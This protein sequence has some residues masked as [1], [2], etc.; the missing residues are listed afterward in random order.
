[1]AL[2][3]AALAAAALLVSVHVRAGPDSA[4]QWHLPR[5]LPTPAVPADNPMSDAKVAL[6]RRLFSDNRLSIDG[7]HSCA[8]CHDP[9]R[10]FTDGRPVAIGA[11]GQSLPHNA[12]ALVNVAYNVSYGWTDPKVTSLEA[13][14]L[15]P[16]LNQHPVELGTDPKA[17]ATALAKDASY[18]REFVAAFPPPAA[19][20]STPTPAVTFDHVVK[21]IAAYERTLTAG[22]SAFDHYV[23][24]GQHDALSPSAKRGMALFF[25]KS[26]GCGR[27]HFGFNFSGHWRDSQGATGKASFANNGIGTQRMRI[28]TLRNIALTA[29]Y[30]HDGRFGTLDAVIDH[31]ASIAAVARHDPHSK[32]DVRLRAFDPSDSDR[33][34]LIAFLE[35]LTDHAPAPAPAD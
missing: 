9:S 14:M 6:G 18:P 10:S 30:M 17:L 11:T 3:A 23:F 25:S 19:G 1:L 27:C 2:K 16:L 7:R 12:M 31:Y 21:A 20:G 24:G 32:L 8:S 4:Y 26:A 34:D 35:S 22:D 5:G 15:Q 33:Q 28:P 13:Q 29:P